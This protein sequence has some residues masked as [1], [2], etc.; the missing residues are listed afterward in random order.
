LTPLP[1]NI[2]RGDT[3]DIPAALRTPQKSGHYLLV[4][5]LCGRNVDW[6]IR[7][8]VI[9]ALVESDIQSG[10]ARSVDTVD[11]TAM[12]NR[13]QKPNFLTAAVSRS[14]LW[15]AAWRIFV[16]HP[17]GIGPD[18]FRLEYGTYIGATRWDTHVY[19]NNLYLE[20]LTGSGIIGLAAFLSL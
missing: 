6:F 14:T 12:Y 17:F 4:V 10:S 16:S 18:N 1:R 19:S 8:G 3:I 15:T 20:L 5:E 2:A 9:P 11:L 7:T 13:G